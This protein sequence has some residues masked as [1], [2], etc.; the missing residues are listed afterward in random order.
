MESQGLPARPVT[1][2]WTH[3][4][5]PRW[6]SLPIGGSYGGGTPTD[7]AVARHAGPDPLALKEGMR[8]DE[9]FR[10]AMFDRSV[11]CRGRSCPCLPI[12]RGVVDAWF[13]IKEHSWRS[14]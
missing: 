2:L 1:A 9:D 12:N 11:G 4:L 8:F 7:A 6:R 10:C 13:R 3:R 5:L 14:S